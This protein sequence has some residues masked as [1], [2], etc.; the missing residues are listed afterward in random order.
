MKKGIV[1]DLGGGDGVVNKYFECEL[2]SYDLSLGMLERNNNNKKVVGV[3]ES[4]AFK[5]EVFYQVISFT[6]LQDVLDVEKVILEVKRV[7]KKN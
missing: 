3:G 5:N 7:L 4:L 2:V 6:V 1:L